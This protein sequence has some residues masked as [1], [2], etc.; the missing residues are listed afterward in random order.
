M[1][2]TSIDC[3]RFASL[4]FFFKFIFLGFGDHWSIKY[5][6]VDAQLPLSMKRYTHIFC[7]FTFDSKCV[8]ARRMQT[9]SHNINFVWHFLLVSLALSEVRTLFD[10]ISR[11]NSLENVF[12][13]ISMSEK[14]FADALHICTDQYLC[15]IKWSEW[16]VT[17]SCHLRWMR[18]ARLLLSFVATHSGH[19]IWITAHTHTY[20]GSIED[21]GASARPQLATN[22]CNSNGKSR[23]EIFNDVHWRGER[24]VWTQF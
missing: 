12:R 17:G 10:T 11:S 6:K 5:T 14:R 3:T 4:F 21:Q 9:F 1:I 22:S 18:S 24:R 16:C 15:W 19:A 20:I 13:S 23:R 2:M 8:W 7:F